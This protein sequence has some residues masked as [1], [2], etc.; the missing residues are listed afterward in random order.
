M[1]K[2]LYVVYMKIVFAIDSFKG[3]MSSLEAASS[4]EIGAKKVFPKAK[5]IKIA[6]ADGGEGTLEALACIKGA[7]KMSVQV[8]N[9]IGKK[10][11]AEYV[12]YK[13][14]G[15]ICS[16]IESAQACGITLLKKLEPM[17]ASTFGLGEIILS[18][19]KNGARKFLIGLGGSATSDGGMGMLA[20]LGAKFFD[21]NKNQIKSFGG[22]NLSKVAT[23][24]FSAIPQDLLKC[25]FEI[26]CDVK[27][28]LYS[29]LGAAYVFSPQKGASS[30][31]VKL[32]DSG[33]KSYSKV[34]A[35]SLGNDVSKNEGAGAAGGLG[36]AFMAVLNAKKTSGIDGVLDALNFTSA[37]KNADYVITGEGRLDRQSAM[38]KTPCGIALRA[39]K[40][41][42]PVFAI[43]GGIADGAETLYD[44]GVS[45]MFAI[46]SSPTSLEDAMKPDVAKKNIANCVESI[47]RI[48]KSNR[49][50]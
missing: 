9:P 33:L 38:G 42:I 29:K 11:V 31:Q 2:N 4:A 50:K 28:P 18:A 8:N 40:Q 34:L 32:L 41:S 35:K 13:E 15:K 30:E 25:E 17:K 43:G 23:A 39:K 22:E 47:F 48:I 44:C 7:K 49:K 1:L 46:A 16:A 36:F 37:I 12:L 20:S 19:Y 24:D 26:L 10:V 6:V 45:A 3:C 5:C 14:K 21:K 27:N